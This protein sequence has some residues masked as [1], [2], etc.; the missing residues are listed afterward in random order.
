MLRAGCELAAAL[1]KDSNIFTTHAYKLSPM[2][3]SEYVLSKSGK[4]EQVRK[5]C[6]QRNQTGQRAEGR[7]S[8][9]SEVMKTLSE[10]Y[11]YGRNSRCGDLQGLLEERDDLIENPMQVEALFALALLMFG[12]CTST[13][14]HGDQRVD[15]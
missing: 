11:K 3:G 9:R 13:S 12:T 2:R 7:Y 14:K 4:L 8:K 15:D 6:L 5:V 1:E 10:V